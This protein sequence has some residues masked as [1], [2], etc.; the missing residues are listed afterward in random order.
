[1]VLISSLD[2]TDCTVV[3]MKA[4][5]SATNGVKGSPLRPSKEET[6]KYGTSREAIRQYTVMIKEQGQH[7]SNQ[8]TVQNNI[9]TESHSGN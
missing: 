6:H 5:T 2:M 8:K 1:M 9:I 3:E 7:V 4:T